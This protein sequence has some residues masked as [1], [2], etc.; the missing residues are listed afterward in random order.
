MHEYTIFSVHR[1]HIRDGRERNHV[2]EPLF[3][4]FGNCKKFLAFAALSFGQSRLHEFESDR[5][6]AQVRK[7]ISIQFWVYDGH[8]LWYFPHRLVVIGD[9]DVNA[10][11]SR[12]SCSGHTVDAYVG[13]ND[14][15][16]ATR[17]EV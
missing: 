8:R 7:R 11:G 1:D 17:G 16:C 6:T 14:E 15:L 4:S 2:E 10:R 13:G 12:G 5:G 3:P 9:D